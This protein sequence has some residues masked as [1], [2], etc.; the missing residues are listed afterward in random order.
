MAVFRDESGVRGRAVRGA[1]VLGAAFAVAALG[2]FL[3]SIFPAPWSRTAHRPEPAPTGKL[4]PGHPLENKARERAYRKEEARLRNLLSRAQEAQRRR[5]PADAREPVLAGFAVNWDPQ[6]LASLQA[7]ADQLTHAMPEWIRLG[8]GGSFLVEEDARVTQ[9]SARLE[10][11]P[12]VSN[13]GDGGFDRRLV[14]PLLATAAA[15]KDAAS[16]LAHLCEERGFA[17]VNLDFEELDPQT[18]AQFAD[19]VDATWAQLHPRGFLLSV[20]VPAE[21]KGVPVER[22]AAATDFLVVMAYDQHASSDNPGPIAA[23]AYVAESVA[24]YLRRAPAEKIVA[25]LGAYGYDWPLDSDGD[26]ARPAEELAFA[27]AL[28]LAR[29]NE[30]PIEWDEESKSSFFEYDDDARHEKHQVRFLD[31]P[32]MAAELE[33]LAPLHLR[34][35]AIWRLGAEDPKVFDLFAHEPLPR[36]FDEEQARKRLDGVIA[37]HDPDDVAQVGEGEVFSLKARPQSGQRAVVWDAQGHVARVDYQQYPS[38]WILERSGGHPGRKVLLTFDD[39]PDPKW[40]PRVLDLLRDRG[41]KA[42]FFVIGENAQAW[43]EL[44]R[45]EFGEG[46]A[47]GN[48][49]FTHPDL[50]RVSPLRMEV[51]LNVTERLLEWILGRQ[52]RLFRPPYH[53]DEALDEAL[54]AQVIARASGMGFLTLGQDIDPEDFA[55]HDPQGIAQRALAHADRGSVIL[56]HDGG[57]D[58]SATLAALPV[59]LDGLAQKGIGLATPEEM[60]GLSRDQLMPAAPRAPAAALLTGA[61]GVV[62]GLLGGLARVLGPLFAFA[63]ALLG[64]RAVLLAILAPLQAR[65]RRRAGQGQVPPGL[66]VSVVVPAYN[67]QDV[68]AR[69]VQSLLEQEPPVLEVICVDDGSKD[70]TLQVLHET[71]DGNPRVRI[72]AKPNGGKASALNLGFGEAMGE[73]VVALDSDTIFTRATVARLTAPFA[74]PRVGA[75]AG[76]AKVGNRVNRLT[77][78][79]ALEYV[80]AQNLERRAWDLVGAVPV[81]PGAV[82]AW[83]RQAVLAE[84]GFH[85]DTLAEDTDL[86]LRLIANGF[87]VVYAEHALAYTEAPEKVASLLRQRFRWTYGVLQACWKHKSRLFH[88]GGGVLGWAILPTFAVYQ[89]LVPFVAPVV[90]LLLLISLVRGQALATA[91]YYLLFFALDLLLSAVAVLLEGEDLALLK[92]LF[93]QRIAYRQLLWLALVKSL[94]NALAGF[95]VGWGKLQRTGTVQVGRR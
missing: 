10:L 5:K 20:D 31:A 37:A 2:A 8:P 41:A 67:E 19:F 7:H 91:G 64:L 81:V 59:I 82:G 25:A 56:L 29:E 24:A 63:I 53:S 76:N 61:D 38:G 70:R 88:R 22:L 55:S 46:H 44:V 77:R 85:E 35:V 39:G 87:R 78:W 42:A 95:A 1:S 65:K 47:V 6:S 62:F 92:G 74:D 48:H 90:D 94:W 4:P 28:A 69:T 80:T 17:G 72:F 36:R 58:R 75:V 34:G 83:R 89:F 51:E 26:T 68:I 73:V 23:P 18:W 57:G 9:A 13:Y 40:T 84:G 16:R 30:V 79:Q 50:S 32:A 3:V 15:R 60:T 86:T 45:R 33:A 27:Q 93:V 52:P 21:V 49:S 66:A 11:T 54:N 43:P 71:F 12:T 14:K